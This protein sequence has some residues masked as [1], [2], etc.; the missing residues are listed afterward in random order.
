M[1]V[2]RPE[3]VSLRARSRRRGISLP[4]LL[5]GLAIMT[6]LSALVAPN[7]LSGLNAYR[8]NAALNT[9]AGKLTVAKYKA[10]AQATDYEI[11]VD[12]ANNDYQFDVL[13]STNPRTFALASNE[14]VESLPYDI[15][16]GYGA[17]TAPAGDPGDQPTLAQSSAI[18]FNSQGV[19]VDSSGVPTAA[20]A[21]YLSNSGQIGAVTVSLAGRVQVWLW[22]G[23][24]WTTE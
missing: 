14:A 12:A 1:C 19:P 23:S 4:E 22:N 17:V 13:T 18:C 11:A 24:A 21:I 5:V 16:F 10:Q 20:N 2:N 9:I 15:S 3:S 8:L 6:V 7:L